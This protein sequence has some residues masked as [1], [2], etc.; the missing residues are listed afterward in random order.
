MS[1]ISASRQAACQEVYLVS[2]KLLVLTGDCYVEKLLLIPRNNQ[3]Q[4]QFQ[5]KLQKK[6]CRV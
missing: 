5:Y 3:L 2:L 6:R 1:T 4:Q